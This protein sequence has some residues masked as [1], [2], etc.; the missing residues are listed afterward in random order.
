MTKVLK[1]LLIIPLISFGQGK[2]ETKSVYPKNI[3]DI[4]FNAEIDNKDF[5][6]CNPKHLV[7]L[8]SL[9]PDKLRILST[10]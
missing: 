8:K 7:N 10:K 5:E 6:L 1:F 4:E 9:L 3:G 2:S